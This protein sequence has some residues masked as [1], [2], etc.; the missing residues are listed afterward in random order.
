MAAAMLLLRSLAPLP[1]T[2]APALP[3]RSA[4]HTSASLFFRRRGKPNRHATE[5]VVLRAPM[6]RLGGVGE[7]AAVQRGYARNHLVPAGLAVYATPLNRQVYGAAAE[8]EA[9][10]KAAAAVAA[11]ASLSGPSAADVHAQAHKVAR[12]LK[13]HPLVIRRQRG[14]KWVVSRDLI[15]ESAKSQVRFYFHHP[16]C[17]ARCWQ[18]TGPLLT[19]CPAELGHPRGPSADGSRQGTQELWPF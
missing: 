18:L 5:D 13:N 19:P 12:Y 3:A 1:A 17:V 7:V 4:L 9:K 10:K 16:L 2:A 6:P 14:N 8:A 11:A 15:V